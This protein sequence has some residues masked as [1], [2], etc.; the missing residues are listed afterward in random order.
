MPSTDS[1]LTEIV[2]VLEAHGLD[3]DTYTL[4]EYFDPD[5]LEE[6]VN[7][8]AASLEVRVTIEGIQLEITQQG[9]RVI[10]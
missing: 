6:L 10:D 1:F 4:Y 9:V 3:S 8:A 5:A 7:S 2:A